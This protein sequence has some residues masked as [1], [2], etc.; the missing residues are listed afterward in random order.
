[1]KVTRMKMRDK[2]KV[3][4]MRMKVKVMRMMMRNKMKVNS[5]RMTVD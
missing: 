4:S 1:M 5:M 2:M 3:K